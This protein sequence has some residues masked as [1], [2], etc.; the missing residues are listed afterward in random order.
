M[1]IKLLETVV[2][3]LEMNLGSNFNSCWWQ[4]D[5]A[6]PHTSERSLAYLRHWFGERIVNYRTAFIRLP[7]SPDLNPLDYWFWSAL[8]NL[9]S[10]HRPKGIAELSSAIAHVILNIQKDPD[11]VKRSIRDFRIRLLALKDKKSP[12]RIHARP[13]QEER[14]SNKFV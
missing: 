5:G 7:K 10:I 12:F 13:L 14:E 2:D 11:I 9:V 4:Q 8:R 3:E 6:S 1:Y